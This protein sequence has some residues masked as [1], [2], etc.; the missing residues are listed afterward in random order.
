MGNIA[1]DGSA[2][3]QSSSRNDTTDILLEKSLGTGIGTER[4]RQENKNKVRGRV[5]LIQL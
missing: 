4:K 1:G 5:R 3:W 2:S